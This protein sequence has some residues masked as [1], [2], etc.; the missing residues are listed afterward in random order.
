MN[1]YGLSL[2]WLMAPLCMCVC[3]CDL[4]RKEQLEP[5]LPMTQEDGFLVGFVASQIRLA[6]Q[7][8]VLEALMSPSHMTCLQLGF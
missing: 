4:S 1:L 7:L 6:S 2:V 8:H 3:V 5:L